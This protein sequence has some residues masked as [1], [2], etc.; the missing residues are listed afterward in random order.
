I[1]LQKKADEANKIL[2]DNVDISDGQWNMYEIQYNQSILDKDDTVC[3]SP[4]VEN[5]NGYEH[6]ASQFTSLRDASHVIIVMAV[7]PI[8]LYILYRISVVMTV[9]QLDKQDELEQ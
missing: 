8:F 4:Y 1:L 2:S 7:L 9:Y 5:E 6:L 3:N